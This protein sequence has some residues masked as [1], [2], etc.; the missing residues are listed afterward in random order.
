[1]RLLLMRIIVLVGVRNSMLTST[2]LR[3]EDFCLALLDRDGLIGLGRNETP[4][5]S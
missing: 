5:I 2:V 3:T 4:D 1:M